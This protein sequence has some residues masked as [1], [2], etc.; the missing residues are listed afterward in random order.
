MSS[1]T[2][3]T[4]LALLALAINLVHSSIAPRSERSLVATLAILIIFEVLPCAAFLIMFSKKSILSNKNFTATAKT[5]TRTTA[6]MAS[7]EQ[8]SRMSTASKAE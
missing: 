6:S 5:R 1:I 4:V 2:T 8:K 7:R 3:F